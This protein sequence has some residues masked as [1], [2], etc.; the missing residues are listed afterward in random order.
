MTC[1]NPIPACYSKSKYAKT[2][3]KELHL[4]LHEFEKGDT[5]WLYNEKYFPHV[6]YEY[7]YIPCRKCVGCRS[8]NAKMWAQRAINEMQMHKDN[9]FITLTYSNDNPLVLDDPLCLVSL[10]YKHFQNFIKRLRKR[11]NMP[12]L[13]YLVSGE[14]GPKDG[15]AHWHAILFG[16]DFPDKEL[17][18]ISKGYNHYS[19]KSLNELWSVY[20]RELSI[21]HPI[22]YTD[23]ANCDA[24]CCNYVAQYV[25]KK[26]D[27]EQD[28]PVFSDV[29][30]DDDG[31]YI[32]VPL[33][34]R[35]P[36]FIRSSRNPAIGLNWFNKYGENAVEKGFIYRPNKDHTSVSKIKT[37]QYYYDKFE[38]INPDKASIIKKCKEDKARDIFKNR[39]VDYQLLSTWQASHLKRISDAIKKK[40]TIF[41]R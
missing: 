30:I 20:N 37:P 21:Y 35:V 29:F 16:F 18:Y 2:G 34:E 13:Q 22:G 26:L 36:P 23:L 38:Q 3:K 9:C 14:Y 28:M 39:K 27:I 33:A 8:D 4:V 40:L 24:D 32:D 10:R 17:V 6:L 19:S 31:N 15:R 11:F 1:Y 41:A 25:L 12:K 5:K 7:I